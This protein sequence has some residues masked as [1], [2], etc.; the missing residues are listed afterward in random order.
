MPQ[1]VARDRPLARLLATPDFVRL[2]LAGGLTNTM[3]MQEILVVGVFAYDLTGSALAVSLVLMVRALPMLVLGALA[4]AL[5]ENLN[6]KRLLMGGQA[7]AAIG[8]FIVALLAASGHLALWH[9]ALSGF[10]GGLV[11]TNEHAT[12]RRMVAEVAGV[13]DIVPAVALDTT[14]GSTTRMIGPLLGGLFFQLLGLTAAYL[15]AGVLY[16]LALWLVRGVRYRQE[17]GAF[18]ARNLLAEIAAAIRLAL[19]HPVIRAVLGVTILMN[20]CVFSY[21]AVLPAFGYQV[22]G[23]SALGIGVLA[24]AEPAGAL[25]GGLI[26]A[27]GRFAFAGAR[28]FVAGSAGFAALLLIASFVPVYAVVVAL[29]F[30]GGIGVAAFAAHQTGLVLRDAPPEARSRLLGL[31]TTCIGT[32]PFGVLAIGALADWAGPAP[33]ISLLAG[34]GLA[35]L[36]LIGL[37]LRKISKI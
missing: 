8:A 15:L 28:G 31:I 34:L 3:R 2:W 16:A 37:S 26:M 19:R 11:W 27:S 36:A 25:L 32:G 20:S 29:L 33:A 21:T 1:A 9:L 35:G 22:F 10:L 17:P 13:R 18:V 7:C 4:G 23:T 14:T 30:L 6:R 5:A 12:R 24:A